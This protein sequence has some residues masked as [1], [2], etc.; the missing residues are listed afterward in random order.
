VLRKFQSVDKNIFAV[1]EQQELNQ[2]AVWPV[3]GGKNC[4]AGALAK[5]CA[6]GALGSHTGGGVLPCGWREEGGPEEGGE[7]PAAYL[8]GG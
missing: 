6:A 7:G 2:W 3:G 4:A 8:A 1:S 5:N